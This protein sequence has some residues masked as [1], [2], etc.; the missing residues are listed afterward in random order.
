MDNS[1]KTQNEDKHQQNKQTNKRQHRKLKR[2]A[3]RTPR[4]TREI[5]VLAKGKQFLLLIGYRRFRFSELPL[6]CYDLCRNKD[7]KRKQLIM[8]HLL[9]LIL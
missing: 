4:T 7:V 9:L 8:F 2:C 1:N 6:I 5:Q 3:T